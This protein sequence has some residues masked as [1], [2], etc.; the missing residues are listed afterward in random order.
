M[1]VALLAGAGGGASVD[2]MVVRALE[3]PAAAVVDSAGVTSEPL[4]LELSDAGSA[5]IAELVAHQVDSLAAVVAAIPAEVDR[6]ARASSRAVLGAIDDSSDR[7]ARAASELNEIR[8][9]LDHM[10][11]MIVTEPPAPTTVVYVVVGDSVSR[12][13]AEDLEG[14]WLRIPGTEIRVSPWPR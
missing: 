13:S 5:A 3:P 10:A 14:G 2:R 12:A 6:R 8:A 9:R 11:S 7:D 4:K 1:L